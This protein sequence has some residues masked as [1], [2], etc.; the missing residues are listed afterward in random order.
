MSGSKLIKL[1]NNDPNFFYYNGNNSGGLG[2]FTQKSLHYGNDRQGDGDS[3][4]PYI[5]T[6]IPNRHFTSP[7]DD[8][9]IRGGWS[10]ANKSSVNDQI[11]ISKFLT[12]KAKG[13]LFIQRQIGLQ[14]TNPKLETR[15]INLNAFG[16]IGGLTTG[17]FNAAND[18]LPGP[19][20]LYNEGKNTL[21]QIPVTAF[22]QHF[23]RHGLS[24]IQDDNTKYLAVA[25][26]NNE[27]GNNRLIG[28][29][30]KLIKNNIT[31]PRSGN[32]ILGV[33]NSIL[34][35]INVFN[36]IVGKGTNPLLPTLPLLQP[37]DLII[38]QYSGGPGSVYGVGQTIIRRYDVTSNGSNSQAPQE[39]G[40]VNYYGEL[41]LSL[42][43]GREAVTNVDSDR[44]TSRPL[45]IDQ[46]AVDYTQ[47]GDNIP[48]GANGTTD[49][50]TAR[51][52]DDLKSTIAKFTTT[53][54]TTSTFGFRGINF[55]KD[56]RVIIPKGDKTVAAFTRTEDDQDKNLN[57][58]FK[59]INPFN[60]TENNTLIFSAYIKGFRDNFDGS[61]N[62]INYAGRS[63]TFFTYG[64]YK[65]NVS[66]NLDIPCFK[67]EDLK[68]NY[69]KLGELASSTAGAYNENGLL[70]GVLIQLNVGNYIKNEYSILNNISYEIPDD[71]S[72]DIDNKL[73]MY[74]KATLSF[75]IIHNN[76]KSNKPP[77][78]KGE[79]FLNYI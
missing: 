27:N 3:G 78:L 55:T 35:A 22:G 74:V 68:I 13:P 40:I 51:K 59:L 57:V 63:E 1:L 7:V 25:R 24:Y 4:Q 66:F 54:S 20:R 12:D 29:K 49:S 62:D 75:T 48:A 72:W 10:L 38:D 39:K 76:E 77:Q 45:Q 53:G 50:P 43:Y 18:L 79:G 6:D 11:R 34:G 70:G 44:P 69:T 14:F 73:A 64:K 28:L 41:G 36:T 52:Y 2:N 42:D 26:N 31:D 67:V 37:A 30:N 21:A 15:K 71:S 32:I 58:S 8:G 47:T 19:T 46:T 23:E 17:L 65:R 5:T 60:I 56:K 9:F 33:A 16:F 61:W